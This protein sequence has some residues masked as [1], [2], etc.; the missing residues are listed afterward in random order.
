MGRDDS[1]EKARGQDSGCPLLLHLFLTQ[2][3]ALYQ[4][5]VDDVLRIGRTEA[6]MSLMIP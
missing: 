4:Q 3:K 5:A 2:R 1:K 6:Q